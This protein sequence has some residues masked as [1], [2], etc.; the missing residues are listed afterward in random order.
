MVRLARARGITARIDAVD[1]NEAT[2]EIARR[3]SEEFPEIHL[4]KGDALRYEPGETFDLVHCS[5]ALHH[6]SNEDAVRL[7]KRC[8]ELSTR[9]VLVS[10]LERHPLTTAA[11]WMLT[12][13]LCRD[14]MAVHDGR[15]SAQ[16]A[17]SWGEMR[18]LAVAAG[19]EDFG[20]GRCL[21]CRQALWLENREL[22]EI[23][24]DPVSMPSMA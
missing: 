13:L 23:P 15:L 20:H 21:I 6:F 7:L 22:A 24:L 17:F 18:E 5:L 3:H 10:D 12:A 14:P 16:R 11:I 1:A 4:V 2:I 19:W 8:S 9:W